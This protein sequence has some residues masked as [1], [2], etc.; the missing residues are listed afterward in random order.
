MAKQYVLTSDSDCQIAL[1]FNRPKIKSVQN[2]FH[3]YEFKSVNRK[4]TFD[5]YY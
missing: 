1:V 5:D 2:K 3:N 4:T